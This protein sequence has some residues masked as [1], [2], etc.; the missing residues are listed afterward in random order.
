MAQVGQ[1]APEFALIDHNL[2]EVTL[3]Q[4]RGEKNVILSFHVFSFTSG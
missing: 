3:T 2:N 4:F 1:T